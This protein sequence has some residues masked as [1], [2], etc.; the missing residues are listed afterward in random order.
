LTASVSKDDEQPCLTAF[1]RL[2]GA[3]LLIMI[4]H[5]KIEAV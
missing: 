2:V 4:V 1:A 5:R 3:R